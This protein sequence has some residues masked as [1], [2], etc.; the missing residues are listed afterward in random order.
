MIHDIKRSTE[1]QKE[2]SVNVHSYLIW[3]QFLCL[4]HAPTSAA[5]PAVAR[6]RASAC[7]DVRQLQPARGAWVRPSSTRSSASTA[8]VSS[9]EMSP[10]RWRRLDDTAAKRMRIAGLCSAE[11]AETP[12]KVSGD[13]QL[14]PRR[15]FHPLYIFL[16]TGMLTHLDQRRR[17]FLAAFVL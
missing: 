5:P 3:G 1:V 8:S 15:C 7:S 10:G 4:K 11:E 12:R 16:T 14:W 17:L 2:P 9:S 13:W 6:A